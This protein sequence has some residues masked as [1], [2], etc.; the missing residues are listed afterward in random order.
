VGRKRIKRGGV[1]KNLDKFKGKMSKQLGE[2][3]GLIISGLQ[4]GGGGKGRQKKQGE[5][6]RSAE[7]YRKVSS[8]W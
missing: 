1:G 2:A 3:N 5:K 8:L 6:M 7:S 4:Y